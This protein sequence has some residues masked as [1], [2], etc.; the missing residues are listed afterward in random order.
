MSALF[1]SSLGSL[2]RVVRDLEPDMPFA[3][4][5]PDQLELAG[6]QPLHQRPAM[7]CPRAAPSP[8]R[9][10][11]PRSTTIPDLKPGTY[12]VVTVADEGTG[13]PPEILERVCEPFLHHQGPWGQG[14]GLGLAMVFGLAQ[15]AGGRLRITSEVGRG[16]RI[17][18]ALPRAD[19]GGRGHGV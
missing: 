4:V 2:V 15:Q 16:T 14:T 17:E 11:A 10:A 6:A 3:L 18:L 1:G 13:I 9:R 12:A 7:P 19:G 8:S 5:D